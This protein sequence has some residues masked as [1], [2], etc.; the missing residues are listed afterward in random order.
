MLIYEHA[1]ESTKE[2]HHRRHNNHFGLHNQCN[3]QPS[4]LHVRFLLS[5]AF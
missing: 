1:K 5:S 2:D 3:T 4:T